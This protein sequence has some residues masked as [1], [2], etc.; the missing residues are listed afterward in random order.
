[1]AVDTRQKR[2]S[3]MTMASRG[4]I[5]ITQPLF[6]ADAGGVEADDRQ[7]LLGC[8]GGIAFAQVLNSLFL[9]PHHYRAGYNR[10]HG[11]YSD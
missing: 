7:H 10:L 4:L 2:F 11:G 6:E 1:M 9:L 8:Y 5:G 3:I